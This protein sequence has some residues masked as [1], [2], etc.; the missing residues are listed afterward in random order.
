MHDALN[1]TPTGHY[2]MLFSLYFAPCKGQIAFINESL[3]VVQTTSVISTIM[4]SKQEPH[5]SFVA[6][7]CP[8]DFSKYSNTIHQILIY[9]DDTNR[10]NIG[11]DEDWSLRVLNSLKFVDVRSQELKKVQYS[12]VKLVCKYL[13]LSH[14]SMTF[15][16][17]A[18]VSVVTCIGN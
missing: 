17:Y 1:R 12:D 4:S 13:S 16:P 9:I 8:Q 14:L 6:L 15:G 2:I 18:V 3:S 10:Y 7:C 11:S 5:S